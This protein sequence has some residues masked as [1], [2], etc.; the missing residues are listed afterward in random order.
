MVCVYVPVCLIT[1]VVVF[2]VA[3]TYKPPGYGIQGQPL[4]AQI[5]KLS[6]EQ[7]AAIRRLASSGRFAEAVQAIGAIL[8]LPLED[9]ETVAREL[10]K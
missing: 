7:L 9:A 3:F 1:I 8:E 10:Q 6:E 2:L 4:Q 5:D